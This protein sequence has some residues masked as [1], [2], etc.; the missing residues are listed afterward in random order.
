MSAPLTAEQAYAQIQQL[1]QQVA[2]QQQQLV[3]AANVAAAAGGAHAAAPRSALSGH[4]APSIPPYKGSQATLDDW[5]SLL[6]K[7]FRWYQ[8]A[9]A[10]HDAERI[11]LAEL[12][13]EGAALDWWNQR[14]AAHGAGGSWEA[15]VHALRER[16]QPVSAADSARV[17]LDKLRQDKL[18]VNDYVSAFRRLII[19]IPSMD[20]QSQLHAFLRGLRPALA[21]KLREQ[22]IPDVNA[23]IERASRIDNAQAIY[24]SAAASSSSSAAPAHSPMD[25][26]AMLVDGIEGLE[27]DTEGNDA[28]GAADAPITRRE[29]QQLLNAMQDKRR[30]PAAPAG[31]KGARGGRF[32][33]RGPPRIPHLTEEQVKEYMAAGKCFGCGSTDHSARACPK[34]KV[35]ADG[36]PSWGNA[37]PSN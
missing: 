7:Q 28:D 12:Y 26:D 9:G 13:L 30:G 31:G 8:L 10:E 19:D 21:L 1:Q 36:R 14:I 3:A 35:D 23:A 17:R 25:L 22:T 24:A 18:S 34:R 4:K 5:L 2:L 16:F 37:K 29:F 33:P 15:F 32:Q 27:R 6:S 11:R 20:A